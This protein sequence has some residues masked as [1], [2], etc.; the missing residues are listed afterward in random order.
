MSTF[1]L[2]T[3]HR[4]LAALLLAAGALTSETSLAAP[5]ELPPLGLYRIDTDGTMAFSGN[6][7][8][9]RLTTEGEHGDTTAR[10][11]A[12]ANSATRE[13]KGSAPVTHCVKAVTGGTLPL[14]PQAEACTVQSITRIKDGFT[15]TANCSFGRLDL[16]VHQ[17]D[18]ERWEFLSDMTMVTTGAAPN[19]SVLSPL[20]KQQA[21]HGETP[22]IRAR[23]KQQ[24]AELPGMQKQSDAT[25]AATIARM[26]AEM[27]NSTDPEEKA[28][29]RMALDRM[30]AGT[31]TMKTRSRTVWTRISHTCDSGK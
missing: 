22:E 18:K 27:E 25:Y 13:F 23:A 20:L 8:Q 5:I 3:T 24:L 2:H 7:T 26:K 21:E 1:E 9:V 15:Q 14:P 12:G 6:P 28:G 29:I 30:Q 11:Q 31:P 10:W 17:L 19:M 4:L 16:T